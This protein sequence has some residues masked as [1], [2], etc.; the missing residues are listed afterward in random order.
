[1]LNPNSFLASETNQFQAFIKRLQAAKQRAISLEYYRNIDQGSLCTRLSQKDYLTIVEYC[2][3]DK[4]QAQMATLKKGQALRLAKKDTGLPRTVAILRSEQGPF[5]FIIDTKSKLADKD[6]L[7]NKYKKIPEL[8]NEKPN[9]AIKGSGKTAWCVDES[10]KEIEYFNLVVTFPKI[11]KDQQLRLNNLMQEAQISQELASG[12]NRINALYLGAKY[13]KRIKTKRSDTFEPIEEIV[14]VIS[15]YAVKGPQTL[16]KLLEDR[17]LAFEDKLV[18]SLSLLKAVKDIHDKGYVHQDLKPENLLVF[19]DELGQYYI[20]IIDFGLSN[21]ATD[22][23]MP[24]CTPIYQSPEMAWLYSNPADDEHRFYNFIHSLGK[25]HQQQQPKPMHIPNKLHPA[26]DMYALGIILWQLRNNRFM[27]P[28]DLNSLKKLDQEIQSDPLLKGLLEPDREKRFDINQAIAV[29]EQLMSDNVY[30]TLLKIEE[31]KLEFPHLRH[32]PYL[33]DVQTSIANLFANKSLSQKDKEIRMVSSLQNLARY[34]YSQVSQFNPRIGDEKI[35]KQLTDAAVV[36]NLILRSMPKTVREYVQ[37]I[38][39]DGFFSTTFEVMLKD[40]RML[41]SRSP[42]THQGIFYFMSTLIHGESSA[43]AKVKQITTLFAALKREQDPK[44]FLSKS[45]VA[46]AYLHKVQLAAN[47][48]EGL[49]R[50]CEQ[51]KQNIEKIF[52]GAQGIIDNRFIEGYQFAVKYAEQ[53]LEAQTPMR[54]KS[55]SSNDRRSRYPL[56]LI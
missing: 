47:K 49:K 50:L 44:L 29:L 48:N 14:P 46:Y 18:L 16:T 6:E 54:M 34:Q 27:P 36:A 32:N 12:S 52:P 26:N 56:T 35:E 37:N 1:M 21:K 33:Q 40:Y 8:E 43:Q 55:Q 45:Q 38:K 30:V 11:A 42:T 4:V 31:L 10:G 39:L 19:Q 53:A 17:Y 7:T 20:K 41:N 5:K 13:N 2:L 28:F 51:L 25:Y 15:T 9:G 24:A 22:T 3:S 23:I